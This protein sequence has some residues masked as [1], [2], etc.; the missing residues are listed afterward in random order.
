AAVGIDDDLAA[1]EPGI[2]P[3]AAH[4]PA[5]GRVQVELEALEPELRGN[6][7]VHD[8]GAEHAP[9]LV[10]VGVRVVLP[11]EDHRMNAHRAAAGVA[12]RDLALGVRPEW[13][14]TSDAQLAPAGDE[15]GG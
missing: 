1:G 12:H 15:I 10:Q 11:G 9:H 7:R 3:G 6:D 4:G 13:H 2:A 14:G 5:A 8:V